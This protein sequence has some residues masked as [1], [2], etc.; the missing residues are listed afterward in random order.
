MELRCF[1]DMVGLIICVVAIT[2]MVGVLVI[3][4]VKKFKK[5]GKI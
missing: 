5:K 2:Y 3:D 4:F 1:L